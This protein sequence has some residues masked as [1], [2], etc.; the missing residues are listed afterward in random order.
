VNGATARRTV[1]TGDTLALGL[2][3][4]AVAFDVGFEEDGVSSLMPD[5]LV[6]YSKNNHFN[7]NLKNSVHVHGNKVWHQNNHFNTDLKKNNHFET[8]FTYKFQLYFL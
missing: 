2:F 7:N 1:L 4:E 8:K 5:A 3:E 6:S